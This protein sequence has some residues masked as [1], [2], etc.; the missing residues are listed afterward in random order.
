MCVVHDLIEIYAGDTFAFDVEGNKNK[1]KREKEAADKLFSQ[2]P[3]EQGT[4]IRALWDE[5]EKCET[6]DS[7]YAMT[8]I[9]KSQNIVLLMQQPL[10]QVGSVLQLRLM[11]N[12]SLPPMVPVVLLIALPCIV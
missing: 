5:F 10:L 4:E 8:V 7:I 3:E 6:N 11:A 2:L 1:A 12:Q 9:W